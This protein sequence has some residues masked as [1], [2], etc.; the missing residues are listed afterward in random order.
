LRRIVVSCLLGALALPAA[1]AGHV[2]RPSDWPRYPG[3]VPKLRTSGPRIVVCRPDSRRRI[4]QL[5]SRRMRARNLRLLRACRTR[6]IQRA[7]DKARNGTR[8][9]LLPGVYTEPRS[10]AMPDDDP[11]CAGLKIET[12]EGSMAPS[13]DYQLACPNAQNLIAIIGDRDKDRRCDSK[14]NLQITGTARRRDVRIVGDR[15][16]LNVIR[17]DR[18]DGLYLANFT[19]QYSGFNNIYVIETNGFRFRNIVSRWSNEYG[20]LSF[21]SENGLYEHLDAYGNGDSGVYPGSGSQGTADE[22]A[23]RAYGTELRYVNSHDNNLGY[24]GTAG[25]SVWVHDSRFHH[26]AAGLATDSFAAGHPG[27]PQH[28][29]KWERNKIYSNNFNVFTPERQEYCKRPYEQRDPKFVCSAFQV[30]VGTGALIAGGN[31]NLVRDNR[32]Y[33]NWRYGLMLFWVPAAARGEYDP[34]KQIDTSFDN[35]YEHNHMGST[36]DDARALNGVD[37]WWDE[38]GSGNCWTQNVGAGGGPVTSDPGLLPDCPGSSIFS[39]GRPDKT[40]KMA[41][42]ATWDPHTNQF[43][44]GC[45]WFTTPPRPGSSPGS[46]GPGGV[47][48][49]P[50]ASA[51]AAAGPRTLRVGRGKGPLAWAAPPTLLRQALLPHDRIVTGRIVN[52]SSRTVWLPARAM[53]IMGARGTHLRSSAVFLSGFMH[54]LWP[55]NRG[56]GAR[57]VR[58]RVRT[59]MLLRLRPGA[60]APL[61]VSWRARRGAPARA[62]RWQRGVL[63]LR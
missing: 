7:V 9:L 5:P 2:E 3:A 58:E 41:P 48:L 37:F 43:P 61:T 56:P 20:F 60:S 42:C 13:Y 25:D 36:P 33:D 55:F 11:R 57:P 46:G 38:E 16:K 23:C 10:R 49:P 32:V 35:H 52:R 47:P 21:A 54:R 44:P 6:Q 12:A 26:N 27:M 62:I 15:Y 28:C 1:A 8:I 40:A 63:P 4:G 50:A 51:R 53:R 59:G 31:G 24:S 17:G 18:A 45:D 39:P 19:I 22:R 34:A 29:A 30:P 14:C